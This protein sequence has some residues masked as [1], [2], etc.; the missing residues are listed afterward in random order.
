[1]GH[2]NSEAEECKIQIDT[3][4]FVLFIHLFVQDRLLWHRLLHLR[5]FSKHLHLFV[6]HFFLLPEQLHFLNPCPPPNEP[7]EM[8]SDQ[9]HPGLI[10]ITQVNKF[11]LAHFKLFARKVTSQQTLFYS[12]PV[13]VML[14][15]RWFSM[16]LHL[17]VP[18]FFL[19]PKQLHFINP[20][21]PPNEPTETAS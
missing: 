5:W 7:I 21:P 4:L 18:L 15:L 12:N 6:A 20:C 19:L 17:F 10:N 11:S 16:H 1:M 9:Q 8:A 2:P 14:H 3:G 13:E